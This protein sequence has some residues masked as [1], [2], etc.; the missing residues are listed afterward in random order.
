MDYAKKTV[1]ITGG[2]SGLGAAMADVFAAEGA[3]L[4]LLDIDRLRAEQKAAGLRENG[5]DALALAVDVA[6][7][8]SLAGAAARVEEHFGPCHVLCVNVGVQ[9]FGALDKLT[10]DD[11]SWVLSVNVSGAIDT[12]SRFLPLLRKGQGDRHVVITSSSS[13][14][15]P[16]VRM[17]AYITSKYALVGYGEV[18]RQ[19]L[20]EE[21]INV[22]LLFPGG[23]TTRHL[24]SSAAARPAER[25]EY[26]LEREDIE[27]MM[28]GA[29]MAAAS[30]VASAEYAV[31]NLLAD[32]KEHRRY[33][34][35]HGDYRRQ[36]EDQQ[37]EVLESFDRMVESGGGG[38]PD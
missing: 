8:T 13:F 29:G 12:V 21:G 18:L 11:W 30:H 34:I 37:R 23:M 31:R 26:R 19:E 24:E 32:L 7:E 2:G 38:T 33:I 14:F 4:A 20:A 35:T 1:V 5:V 36:I 6:D 25:G 15:T 3:R 17:G 10:R 16:A 22:S 28:R 27:T 9:Q